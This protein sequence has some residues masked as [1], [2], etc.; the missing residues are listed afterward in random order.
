M[1]PKYAPGPITR[2]SVQYLPAA[3][4]LEADLLE[5]DSILLCHL[6]SISL[7]SFCYVEMVVSDTE[8]A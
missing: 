6:C 3:Q 4:V 5:S 1:Q 2:I 8:N 7:N